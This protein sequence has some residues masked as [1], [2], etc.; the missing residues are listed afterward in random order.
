MNESIQKILENN[1]WAVATYGENLNVVP[2]GIKAVADDQTLILADN[3]MGKT[4]ANILAGGLMAISAYDSGSGQ[5]VQVKGTAEYFAEG[6]VFQKWHD[7]FQAKYQMAPKGIVKLTIEKIYST[8]PGPN[9][10][11]ELA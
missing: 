1:T 2:I 5:G 8:T 3:F 4:K 9:A 11:K 7:A 10:G 6:P